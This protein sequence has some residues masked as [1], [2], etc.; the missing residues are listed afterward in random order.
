MRRLSEPKRLEKI[1][2][3]MTMLNRAIE[4]AS[5]EHRLTIGVGTT[6]IQTHAEGQNDVSV[7][8]I[9]ITVLREVARYE[10]V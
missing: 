6:S 9:E 1:E 7:T 5:L 4:S 2:Q 8:Q 3:L 10:A